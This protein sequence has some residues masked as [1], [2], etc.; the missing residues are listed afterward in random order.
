MESTTY[1][2]AWLLAALLAVAVLSR[3]LART[4]RRQDQRRAQAQRLLQ[5]LQRYSSWVCAQR[6][7]A[8]FQGEG[9]EGAAALD[10]ACTIRL[11]WFPDLAAEMAEVLAVHNRLLHFLGAQQALWLRDP[12]HWLESDHDQ[13]FLA[14]WRQH[15]FALEAL[16]ARLEQ[17]TSVRIQ[18]STSAP[19]RESTYA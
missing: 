16:L 17:A 13:R 1:L 4:K 3:L 18:P 11:A 5:A 14:L 8:V 19:R 15:R 6:L 2:A 7:V 9:R 12:E 10:E